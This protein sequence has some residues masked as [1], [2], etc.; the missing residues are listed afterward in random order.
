MPV[1]YR[2]SYTSNR[3]IFRVYNQLNQD[4]SSQFADIHQFKKGSTGNIIMPN[5]LH[6]RF[7]EA[8]RLLTIIEETNKHGQ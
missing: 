2:C 1:R 3:K 5:N 6:R 7:K 4:V 8:E